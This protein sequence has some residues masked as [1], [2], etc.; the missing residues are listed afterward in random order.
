L[1]KRNKFGDN[2]FG[3]TVCESYGT[4]SLHEWANNI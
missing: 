1:K 2:K 4:G 3:T